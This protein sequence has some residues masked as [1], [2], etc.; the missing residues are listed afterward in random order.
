MSWVAVAI[1]GSAVIGAGASMYG[2]NKA[3]KS[4]GQ[5]RNLEDELGGII[6]QLPAAGAAGLAN[7][8]QYG[9]AYTG[10]AN[11]N[12]QAGLLG[13][14]DVPAF[15]RQHPEFQQ[16]WDENGT[17]EALAQSGH[18]TQLDWLNRAIADAG[19]VSPGSI[20]RS[21]GLADTLGSL[22]ATQDQAN[23]NSA[24]FQRQANLADMQQ[25][26]P[27]A[28]ALRRSLNPEYFAALGGL[29]AAASAPIGASAYEQALGRQAL[30]APASFTNGAVRDVSAPGGSPSALQVELQRQALA[31]LQ[32][33]GS[34]T[35]Q[36]AQRA[37]NEARAAA[38]A[39]GLSYSPGAMADEI[40]NLDKYRRL[41]SEAN[42]QFA[43]AVDAQGFAQRL[44]YDQLGQSAQLANQQADLAR[45][46][47]GLAAADF[48]LRAASQRRDDLALA[49]SLGRSRGTEQFGR[50][51][52]AAQLRAQALY[53]PASILG[54]VDNRLNS[55]TTL[56][57]GQTSFT[58]APD[59]LS[60]ILGYGSD[61]NSVNY[62][63]AAASKLNSA[64]AYTALGGGLLSAAGQLG[65][66][67]INKLA[68]T[69]AT[70][71]A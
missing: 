15:L 42:Q 19:Y 50:L 65:G 34:L 12:L 6:G 56:G 5:Q 17:P 55:T 1:G 44:Q 25:F 8:Q 24:T 49:D 51:A 37:R 28:D 35:E 39:R 22:Q 70:P 38:E 62:N 20:P 29:D 27:G 31:Q 4:T 46:S 16:G 64:N 66:A 21:G 54:T 11:S 48:A 63:A 18:G 40:L 41:R 23:A 58:G 59:Y 2:A 10:L 36:E 7:Q 43:G 52:A 61:L 30:G 68:K 67:W 71:R 9:P 53:D 47:Q 69:P 26:A 60:A 32:T 57:M 14:I 13:G 45:N 3:A 33:G